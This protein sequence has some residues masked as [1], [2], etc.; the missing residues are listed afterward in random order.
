[1]LNSG[2]ISLYQN[3]MIGKSTKSREGLGYKR[4]ETYKP[5]TMQVR[6][7]NQR[8]K[9]KKKTLRCYYCRQY[10]HMRR[11]CSHYFEDERKI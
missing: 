11:H 2:T 10:G 3:L 7:K 4:S 5:T 9:G 8:A 1:M 6:E